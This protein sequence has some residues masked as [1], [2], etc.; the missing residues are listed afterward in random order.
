[1]RSLV[2][3]RQRR[4]ETLAVAQSVTQSS[5]PSP[6]RP[7]TRRPPVEARTT[8]RRCGR[9]S[10]RCCC[11]DLAGRAARWQ[12]AGWHHADHRRGADVPRWPRVIGCRTGFRPPYTD[13]EGEDAE[14]PSAPTGDSGVDAPDL[15]WPAGPAGS[16]GA[17]QRL[18]MVGLRDC[19]VRGCG[20]DEQGD[21]RD[22]YSAVR[23]AGGGGLVGSLGVVRDAYDVRGVVRRPV[24]RWR[25]DKPWWRRPRDLLIEGQDG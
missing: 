21:H 8:W 13:E 24:G 23:T 12:H 5:H 22:R 7:R 3:E 14:L 17:E 6:L 16:V 9:R 2:A 18:A 15:R 25:G 10:R 4:S 20:W 19:H 11:S 1:M